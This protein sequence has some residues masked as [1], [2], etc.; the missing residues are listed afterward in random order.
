MTHWIQEREEKAAATVA[1]IMRERTTYG[2]LDARHARCNDAQITGGLVPPWREC[3]K[4]ANP[5]GILHHE[6]REAAP[7]CGPTPMRDGDLNSTTQR[8]MT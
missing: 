3:L 6:A 8:R 2:F 1:G 5:Q 7:L 4:T